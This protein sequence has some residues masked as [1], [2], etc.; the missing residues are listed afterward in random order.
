MAEKNGDFTAALAN[1]QK[2]AN[3]DSILS[4][5]ALWHLSRLAGASGNLMLERIYL[6]KLSLTAPDSLLSEAV[7]TRFIRNLFESGNFEDVIAKFHSTQ[8]F[9]SK[10][11]TKLIV[12]V[13][14]QDKIF[15]NLTGND[16]KTREN[17]VLLGDAYLQ[18]GK[19]DEARQIFAK[20]VGTLPNPAQPDDFALA[21]A[22]HLDELDGGKENFGKTAPQLTDAEHYRRALIYQFNRNFPLARL[23]FQAVAERFPRQQFSCQF[24]LSNRTRFCAGKQLQQSD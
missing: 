11:D 16:A 7:K 13:P 21:A 15:G 4:E 6:Q 10:K 3:R 1:Y 19:T 9:S 8:N 2:I 23:H 5:Y 18:S 24:A 20:L 22:K 12:V 14:A 17:L